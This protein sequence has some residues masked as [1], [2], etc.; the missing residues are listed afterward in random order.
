MP[1]GLRKGLTPAKILEEAF[2]LVDTGGPSALTMR[3]LAQRLDVAPMAIYNHYRDRD[4]ILDAL[5][6][7]AFARLQG[8][9]F[10]A[11]GGKSWK[12]KLRMVLMNAKNLAGRHP[13]IL[14]LAMTRPNKP[15]SALTLTDEAHQA[16]C[17]AGLTSIQALTVYHTFVMLLQGFPFWQESFDRHYLRADNPEMQFPAGWNANKQFEAGVDWL[18]DSA[19][20]LTRQRSK[21]KPAKR[22]ATRK[23]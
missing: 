15:P 4:A 12:A 13:H 1:S 2:A 7:Q 19:D 5:A 3:A 16:L 18:I 23:P 10:G 9:A 20:Q 17:E 6:E 22:K 11:D 14:R 21:P 8:S